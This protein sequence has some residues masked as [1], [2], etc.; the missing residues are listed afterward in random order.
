[1]G[2]FQLSGF[3]RQKKLALTFGSCV[4]FFA[5][6]KK[7]FLIKPETSKKAC[8]LSRALKKAKLSLSFLRF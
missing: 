2:S 6:K 1:M 4:S 3:L 8:L 7:F 5:K